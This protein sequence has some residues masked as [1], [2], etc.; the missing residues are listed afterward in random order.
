[1]NSLKLAIL[2]AGCAALFTVHAADDWY[3]S[4][5][6]A[7]DTLG[8]LNN[9]TPERIL[10]A[11]KLVKKGKRF[12]LGIETNSRT[13][14]FEPRTFNLTVVQP[15]QAGGATLGPTRSSYNDDLVMGWNGVGSGLDGLGHVGIEHVYYNGAKAAEFVAPDGLKKYGME[16]YPPM[17]ARGVL[18]DMAAFYGKDIVPEGTAFNRAE[19][20]AVLKRQGME[21]RAG[22]VV[23]FHTGWVTLMGKDDAR[24]MSGEPGLGKEGALYL[25]EKNITAV[26][27]D[28]FG[29][30]VVPF[31]PGNGQYDVHQIMLAKNGIFLLE[32][33]NTGPLAAE[34]VHEFMFVLGQ[35]RVTGAVQAIVNPVAIY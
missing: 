1:M 15:N 6:G 18:L 2:A 17:V 11:A 14:T 24:Y 7:E 35:P 31:E 3:P 13:P 21:L 12:A 29:V 20:D 9:V 25:A 10:A 4:R 28:N 33:M 8:G 23:L 16:S 26:G 34:G 27:A 32:N 22:D 5:W 19:I 30:E